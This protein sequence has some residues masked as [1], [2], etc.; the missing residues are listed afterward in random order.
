MRGPCHSGPSAG[1]RAVV[2]EGWVCNEPGQACPPSAW[3][4]AL[5][6]RCPGGESRGGPWRLACPP[7]GSPAPAYQMAGPCHT[8]APSPSRKQ[9]A[10]IHLT[11]RPCGDGSISRGPPLPSVSPYRPIWRQRHAT[12]CGPRFLG[13]YSPSP[14]P[15]HLRTHGSLPWPRPPLPH[16]VALTAALAPA[17]S[18]RRH[19]RGLCHTP[20]VCSWPPGHS[21][22]H[23]G[24]AARTP[25]PEH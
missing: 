15:G 21:P 9:S 25:T 17:T 6:G 18:P 10:S 19:A 20:Q 8:G 22:P 5:R 24:H 23:P 4:Q 11:S 12:A 3:P 7:S 2:P 14:S 16:A 1:P 13:H